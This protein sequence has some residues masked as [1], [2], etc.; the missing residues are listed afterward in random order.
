MIVLGFTDS[1]KHGGDRRRRGHHIADKNAWII[2]GQRCAGQIRAGEEYIDRVARVTGV[3]G[4]G[5]NRRWPD[6]TG[7]ARDGQQITDG[8][9]SGM[10]WGARSRPLALDRDRAYRRAI[11]FGA[12]EVANRA[13]DPRRLGPVVYTFGLRARDRM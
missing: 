12:S 9:V 3:R 10:T 4:E 13:R 6:A 1:L 11:G 5:C 8:I 7:V 2:R